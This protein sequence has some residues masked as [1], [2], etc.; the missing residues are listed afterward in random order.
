MDGL[1]FDVVAA[2]NSKLCR[3]WRD[4]AMVYQ[5][6]RN[7]SQMLHIGGYL[8]GTLPDSSMVWYRSQKNAQALAENFRGALYEV[9]FVDKDDLGVF[10]CGFTTEFLGTGESRSECLVHFPT[11]IRIAASVGLRMVELQSFAACWDDHGRAFGD[12]AR[13]WMVHQFFP[14]VQ[15]EAVE[16][17]ELY[18]TLVFQKIAEPPAL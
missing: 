6:L 7:V 15:K 9:R 18:S 17:L 5:T 8:I 1:R 16:L 12:V 14:D 10:A 3:V 4:E 2:F 11:L 13:A